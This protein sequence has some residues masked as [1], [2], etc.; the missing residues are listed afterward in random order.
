MMNRR[1]FTEKLALGLPFLALGS[2]K[3]S[4]PRLATPERLLPRRLQPGD[5]IG[6]ITPGSFISD[7]DFQKAVDKVLSFGFRV[8]LGKHVRAQR[9]FNAGTDQQRLDDLHLMFSDQSVTGIWCA[10]GG[11]GCSRL[12]PYLDYELIRRNP[13]ALIGFSDITALLNAIYH[14]TGLV[15]FHGPNAGSQWTD[16][17][18][19]HFRAVLMEGRAPHLIELAPENLANP[20]GHYQAFPIRQGTARGRLV[21]GNLALLAA[22]CGTGYLP[23]CQGKLTFIEDIGERPYRIDRMLTQ[24]RQAWPLGQAAGIA[25]GIFEDC[26]PKETELSLS[27]ADTLKDRL[28]GL[29]IPAIYGLS[30]GHIA[31]QCT[32]PIGIEAELDVAAQRITLLE[33]AVRG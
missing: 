30:F 12:L 31:N 25:L 18:E 8:K 27:L 24:L 29:N 6:I 14:K 9:G 26:Q 19:A 2:T 32:L 20:A 28:E 3:A 33:A 1:T 21:G 13:K 5:T 10:R 16:Y 23:D 22:L 7:E 15:G 4:A 17:T 11:Y